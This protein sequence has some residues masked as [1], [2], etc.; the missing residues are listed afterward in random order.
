MKCS[1]AFINSILLIVLFCTS[2][3]GLTG[4]TGNSESACNCMYYDSG[5]HRIIST[6]NAMDAGREPVTKIVAGIQTTGNFEFNTKLKDTSLS[7]PSY[8]FNLALDAQ[9]VDKI[10]SR[11]LTVMVYTGNSGVWY[12]L[13]AG[14]AAIGT[15]GK[16]FFTLYKRGL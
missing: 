6:C 3:S 9:S 15:A 16:H 1:A 13:N 12:K 5:T 4:I 11:G 14:P 8:T 7:I 10:K 2:C